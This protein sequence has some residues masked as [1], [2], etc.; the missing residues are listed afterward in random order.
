MNRT[1]LCAT[2]H[3][4]V[5]LDNLL[6]SSQRPIDSQCREGVIGVCVPINR[7]E[8]LWTTICLARDCEDTRVRLEGGAA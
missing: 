6:D 3:I 1:D 7:V 4:S 5:V 8:A 2:A